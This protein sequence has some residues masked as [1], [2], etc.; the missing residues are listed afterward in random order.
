[1]SSS[2]K[3][4]SL[5]SQDVRIPSGHWTAKA[6][7]IFGLIG[8][9]CL[10]AA[11]GIGMNDP[12][13]LHF[14]FHVSFM[15]FLSI[16]LG[17]LFFVIIQHASAAGWS[18][19][20][21]RMA[22]CVMSSLPLFLVLFVSVVLG[23]HSLFHHW[24]DTEA[25]MADPILSK[26]IAYLNEPFFFVRAGVYFTLWLTMA[27]FFLRNSVKQDVSGDH[28]LS[29][30]MRKFS[31]PCI[32]AFGLSLTFSVFDWVMSIDPH[33]YS[34]MFGVYFFA[35]SAVS[36]YALLVVLTTV[37][38]SIPA[39]G[40]AI[41][42]E[43]QQDLGKLMFGHTAFWAY[44][45]FSQYFLIWYANIPEETLWYFHRSQHGWMAVGIA[46]MVGHFALPFWFLV[47]RTV[48]RSKALVT[49]G[50]LW[51]LGVHFF[52]IFYMI[53][54]TAREEF[55]IEPTDVLCFLGIGG[56]FLAWVFAA[57]KKHGL[58]A[59]KDPLIHESLAFENY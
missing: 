3:A 5:T 59:I 37:F 1:M 11:V 29:R 15:Y 49:C 8:V 38:R 41:T 55:A 48:K 57:L 46:L 51:M 33:W 14:S 42:V 24:T 47:S 28:D 22:E 4:L 30:K 44:V 12:K 18:A 32:A 43:H 19:V 16:A 25:V 31:F 20:V 26:K 58:I 9:V 35:G 54:P 36:V 13:N 21:R 56:L 7:L 52:D 40:N 45:T 27:W 23:M 50:A 53:M 6:P 10:A 17:G 2:H 34:T 39:I